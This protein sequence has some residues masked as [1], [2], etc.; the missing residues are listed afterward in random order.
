MVLQLLL[1]PHLVST[2]QLAEVVQSDRKFLETAELY[3]GSSGFSVPR[4]VRELVE[5]ESVPYLPVHRYKESGL[6]AR[7]DWEAYGNFSGKKTLMEGD[8]RKQHPPRARGAAECVHPQ[9]AAGTSRRCPCAAKILEQGFPEEQFWRLRGKLD[10]PKERWISYPG[11]ER[12]GD[13][14]PLIAWAGW[15]HLQQAQALAEY[16]LDAKTNQGWPATRLKTLLAGLF[17]LLPWLKQW[18]NEIDPDFGMG[19]GDYFGGFLE[20]ECRALDL[21]LDDINAARFAVTPLQEPEEALT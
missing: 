16:Y 13:P 15:D 19:L 20:E 3:H 1:R 2:N 7:K 14:S 12:D 9:S 6:R 11:A 21:T 10:V 8:V 4:I 17:D 5:D 18:H